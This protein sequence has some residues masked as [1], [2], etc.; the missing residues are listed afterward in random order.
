MRESLYRIKQL[1]QKLKM[2][3]QQIQRYEAENYRA[4]IFETL[5]RIAKVLKI[6]LEKDA[7]VR[8]EY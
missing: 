5:I 1:A 4:V 6:D 8:I 2:P 7:V 3:E